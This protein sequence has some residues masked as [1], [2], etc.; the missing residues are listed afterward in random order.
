VARQGYQ[1]ILQTGKSP[2]PLGRR[3]STTKKKFS[4][5]LFFF[6]KKLEKYDKK[7]EKYDLT[8]PKMSKSSLT[9]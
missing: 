7:L 4:I 3:R 5:F 8:R 1:A 2:H 6:L 9:S